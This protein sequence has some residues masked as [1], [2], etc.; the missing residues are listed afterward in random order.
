MVAVSITIG[1]R[2]FL[3]KGAAK[4]YIRTNVIAAFDGAPQIPFGPIH[5][6]VED[7]FNLHP[8]AVDKIGSSGIDHFRV[9]PASDWKT[10]FPVRAS[11]RTLVVVPKTGPPIDWSWD[12]IIK[13]PSPVMQKRDALRNA[14]YGRIQAI[15]VAA[16][17]AGPVTCARTGLPI[18]GP[19]DAQVRYHLPTFAALTDG[20]AAT[21]GGWPAIAT[22]STGAG[23]ELT[24]PT[25]AA[26]WVKYF[27]ANVV[28]SVELKY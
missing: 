18:S 5:D 11:N 15:K 28:P 25:V 20:F 23:A 4:D 10:G 6:F 7:L 26:D 21:V 16:F 1:G 3:T 13:N 17:S 22:T 24:S 8:D 27:D 2:T 12:G 19:D 14:V 9:D